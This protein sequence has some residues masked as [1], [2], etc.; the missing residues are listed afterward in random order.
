MEDWKKRAQEKVNKLIAEDIIKNKILL[1]LNG[2]SIT[3]NR[4][5]L[6][7]VEFVL[8]DQSIINIQE[9]HLKLSHEKYIKYLEEEYRLN[10]NKK[11][12]IN[13]HNYNEQREIFSK[14]RKT[15]F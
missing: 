10:K 9:E 13:K 4:S 7:D 5:I 1:L 14:R 3:D 12:K 8:R 2:N 6:R 11:K 15:S